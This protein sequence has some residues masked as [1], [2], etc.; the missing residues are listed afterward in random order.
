MVITAV[1]NLT[2]WITA[3]SCLYLFLVFGITHFKF[4]TTNKGCK[5]HSSQYYRDIRIRGWKTSSFP[6]PKIFISPL[7]IHAL[8]NAHSV[9]GFLYHKHNVSFYVTAS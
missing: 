7:K 9:V 6:S 4:Y 2:H 1:H 5:E 8:Q 3:H